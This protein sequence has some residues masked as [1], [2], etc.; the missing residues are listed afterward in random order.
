MT[1]CQSVLLIESLKKNR[2]NFL[3]IQNSC[4][5]FAKQKQN[6]DAIKTLYCSGGPPQKILGFINLSFNYYLIYA[7]LVISPWADYRSIFNTDI[8]FPCQ[9]GEDIREASNHCLLHYKHPQQSDK[10]ITR[11]T[12]FSKP[13]CSV[14][15]FWRG[16]ISMQRFAVQ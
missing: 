2:Y 12:V 5:R 8:S 16:I 14:R 1:G 3:S 9:E 6:I 4:T 7:N 15:M 13:V 11:I 10:S